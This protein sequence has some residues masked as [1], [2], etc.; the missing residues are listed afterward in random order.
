MVLWLQ[1]YVDARHDYCGVMDDLNAWWPKLRE[2][3]LAAGHDY[4]FAHE[5][6][7]HT[8]EGAIQ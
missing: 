2:G 4:V 6:G 8:K 5:V 1:I 7:R 3:G